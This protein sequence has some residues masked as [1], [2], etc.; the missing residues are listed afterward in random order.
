MIPFQ[1]L[2]ISKIDSA[3]MCL[4]YYW[5]QEVRGIRPEMAPKRQEAIDKGVK[6]DKEVE[7]WSKGLL[8]TLTGAAAAVSQFYPRPGQEG[9]LVQKWLKS[10]WAGVELRGCA[11]LVVLAGYNVLWGKR[12]RPPKNLTRVSDL[13]TMKSLR[14]A[15]TAE[16][17][18][19]NRQLLVYG[20][21]L[22]ADG[23]LTTDLFEV[24]QVQGTRDAPFQAQDT[25]RTVSMSRVRELEAQD[26]EFVPSIIA[27]HTQE[28]LH[29]IPA[30]SMDTCK[31]VYGDRCP[32]YDRCHAKVSVSL[33]DAWEMSN[34]DGRGGEGTSA[35]LD[36]AAKPRPVNQFIGLY[37]WLSN[38]Y[39]CDV[40]MDV[41]GKTRTFTSAEHA[42]QAAKAKTIEDFEKVSK[43]KTAGE[44]KRLG[45]SVQLRDDWES[46]KL[47][48]MEQV[49]RAKFSDE[50]LRRRLLSTGQQELIEGNTWGDV[51]WGVNLETGEGENHLG[52]LLMKVREEAMSVINPPDASQKFPTLFEGPDCIWISDIVQ[53]KPYCSV[54]G[55]RHGQTFDLRIVGNDYRWLVGCQKQATV[56]NGAP[57]TKTTSEGYQTGAAVPGAEEYESGGNPAYRLGESASAMV[58]GKLDADLIRKRV[59]YPLLR[60]WDLKVNP[61]KVEETP[62]QT[63]DVLDELEG[64]LKGEEAP[65]QTAD[66]SEEI[67][68]LLAVGLTPY[69]AQTMASAGI[70]D[71]RL[72]AGDVQV[73][74][75][76]RLRQFSE[77][78]AQD[79]LGRYASVKEEEESEKFAMTK[80]TIVMVRTTSEPPIEE[81]EKTNEDAIT[82]KI[83]VQEVKNMLGAPMNEERKV[84][85]DFYATVGET[86]TTTPSGYQ[87]LLDCDVVSGRSSGF[88]ATSLED[89][90]RSYLEDIAKS[91]SVVD[92]SLVQAFLLPGLVAEAL[93]KSPPVLAGWIVVDSSSQEWA[94]CRRFFMDRAAV[95]LRSTK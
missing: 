35:A 62:S 21:V 32:F 6:I 75:L 5:H 83:D 92:V 30:A 10:V 56:R 52:R 40:V 37:G 29:E 27:L 73:Q 4:R 44:A 87:I 70:T 84:F 19:H 31:N 78:K 81:V 8:T 14:Y 64:S 28:V 88:L 76:A 93:H 67:A 95:V 66:L 17:L 41:A 45:K 69:Q 13:K 22:H 42:Y 26:R 33:E 74:E 80:E 2:S 57:S 89:I 94:W 65:A 72:R 79:I 85:A 36:N 24:A 23:L 1:R 55:D 38:F 9:V 16:Q 48:V 54:I 3:E 61:P 15:K 68:K 82:R 63:G 7:N 91:K 60:A 59:L 58:N 47:T 39:P 50:V 51:F 43:A 53:G 18:E 20:H 49:L 86:M 34:Q 25:V 11:D 12:A 90:L 77:R 71:A 46:V